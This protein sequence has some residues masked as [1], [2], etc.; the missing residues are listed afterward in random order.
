MTKRKSKRS[1]RKRSSN[2]RVGIYTEPTTSHI[3]ELCRGE[4][5]DVKDA[6]VIIKLK[7]IYRS[8]LIKI[9]KNAG[10]RKSKSRS[11]SHE[12]VMFALTTLFGTRVQSKLED[13]IV[14]VDAL[15]FRK[16]FN[17]TLALLASRDKSAS[18]EILSVIQKAVEVCLA[19]AFLAPISSWQLEEKGQD[20]NRVIT[21]KDLKAI[22]QVHLVSG[23]EYH[24]PSLVK[25]DVN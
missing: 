1:S 12:D 21:L 18:A 9:V 24:A 23:S 6:H 10:L 15:R 11:I 20:A 3:K 22:N 5:L 16:M 7:E 8:F 25:S 19:K 17:E 13:G 14:V 2:V 4:N